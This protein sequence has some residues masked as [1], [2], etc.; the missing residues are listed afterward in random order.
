MFIT[1]L[2]SCLIRQLQNWII[3]LHPYFPK[4]PLVRQI[5][6][7]S[8]CIWVE[9]HLALFCPGCNWF[10]TL[11]GALTLVWD[12][13]PVGATINSSYHSITAKCGLHCMPS[14]KLSRPLEL[15][16]ALFI[17]Y[18]IIILLVVNISS[19]LLCCY[20]RLFHFKS[21]C[22]DCLA[23]ADSAKGFVYV[24][25]VLNAHAYSMPQMFLMCRLCSVKYYVRPLYNDMERTLSMLSS[26][27]Y[28]QF[29]HSLTVHVGLAQAH[30]KYPCL[31]NHSLVL[32][33]FYTSTH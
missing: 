12:V 8:I 30:S 28:T 20:D 3:V 16:K 6:M 18:L 33:L 17:A 7:Q 25:L 21:F 31:H 5:N 23:F 14:R 1:R 24:V 11:S 27:I 32:P 2:T 15:A 29:A 19:L 9:P 22:F 13:W 26:S 10:V 4:V